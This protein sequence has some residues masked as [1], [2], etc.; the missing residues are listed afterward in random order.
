MA[1]EYSVEEQLRLAN[2]QLQ[3]LQRQV[4]V[5]MQGGN[6]VTTPAFQGDTGNTVGLKEPV[7]EVTQPLEEAPY[8]G[9][10]PPPLQTLEVGPDGC[11]PDRWDAYGRLM[12]YNLPGVA[13]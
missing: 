10:G 7:G 5:L 12:P 8:E 2:L 13:V 9:E 11:T 6:Q 3:E 1:Q 4:A